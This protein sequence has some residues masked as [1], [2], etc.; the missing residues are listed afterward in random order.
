MGR[1]VGYR[2]QA[3]HSFP[4]FIAW[5]LHRK[6]VKGFWQEKVE[7]EYLHSTHLLPIFP[8]TL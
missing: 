8:I 1:F 5:G 2:R 4:L 3:L 6:N 7:N